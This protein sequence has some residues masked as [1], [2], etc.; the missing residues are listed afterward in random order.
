MALQALICAGISLDADKCRV[1]LV[2][3]ALSGRQNN[4]YAFRVKILFWMWPI[5]QRQRFIGAKFDQ[6]TWKENVA[7][8]SVLD[9]KDWSATKSH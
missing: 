9:D 4:N 2:G 5:I 3:I 6:E 7:V 1:A 8:A